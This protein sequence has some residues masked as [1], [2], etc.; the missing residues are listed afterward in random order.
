VSYRD[1]EDVDR[2]R[3]TGYKRRAM[4][5]LQGAEEMLGNGDATRSMLALARDE[6][7]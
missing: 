7:R 6:Q 4:D 5:D 3:S 1:L 2:W